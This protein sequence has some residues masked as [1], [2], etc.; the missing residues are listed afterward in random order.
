[1]TELKQYYR[2][3][4]KKLPAGSHKK[5]FMQELKASVGDWLEQN[6]NA[7]LNAVQ[8]RFG[9]P[10]RIAADYAGEM[11]TQEIIKKCKLRKWIISIVAGATALALAFWLTALIAAYIDS[12]KDVNGYIE[13][14]PITEEFWEE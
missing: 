8:A 9:T 10:E 13:T 2:S 4:E 6:P 7:D 1:M 11:D 14:S 12:A 3:I 5:R